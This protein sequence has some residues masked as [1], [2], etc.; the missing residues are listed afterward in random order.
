M[1]KNNLVAIFRR[2][3]RNWMVT[4]INGFGLCV[5]IAASVIIAL[6]VHYEYSFDRY[7]K[8][9]DRIVRVVEN[10]R[11]ADNLLLQA[12]TAPPMGPAFV[13][14]F[15]EVAAFVRFYENPYTV[16]KGGK[17]FYERKAYLVDA[18]VFTVF[19]FQLLKGNSESALAAPHSLVLT[20]HTA[21]KYFGND[22]P[23]GQLL[24]LDRVP[25]TVTGVMSD[26]PENSHFTF[27]FLVSFSTYSTD[28]KQEE[29]VGWFSNTVYTYLLLNTPEDVVKLRNRMPVFIEKYIGD[30]SRR[31]RMFYEDLPLQP[32]TSI[33]LDTPRALE[34]GT[35][36]SR[37][38]LFILCSI[39]LLIIGLACINYIN[40]TTAKA[41]RL[42]KEVG[43]RKILG[44]TR[45][46]L[47]VQFLGESM[48]LCLGATTIGLLIVLLAL[49]SFNS[50]METNL[51][52]EGFDQTIFWPGIGLFSLLLGGISGIYPALITSDISPL[53]TLKN[54][55]V[56]RGN[57][58]LRKA[59]V[60]GQ[61]AISIAIITG[62]LIVLDQLE[63]M[64]NFKVGYDKQ[65]TLIIDF[66]WDQKI[67][68]HLEA[69][70]E[71]LGRTPNV[72]SIT[73]SF[74]VPG[75]RFPNW[76][77]GIET[78]HGKMMGFS[79]NV[80][81]VD[82]D[83]ITAYGIKLVAGRNFSKSPGDD[84]TAFIINEAAVKKFGWSN[85]D[86]IG[87]KIVQRDKTGSVI[88][89]VEDFHYQSLHYKVEPLLLQI[90]L[91]WC[92]N[93]SIKL[94]P[95]DM[96]ITIRALERKW[97]T[98][99]DVP[100][101][102]SLLGEDNEHLYKSERSLSLVAIIFSGLAI[103]IAILGLLGLTTFSVERRVREIGIR[104]VLGSSRLGIVML[105]TG[106]FIGPV[107]LAFVISIPLAIWFLNG[108]LQTFAHH[109][110]LQPLTFM[111]AGAL[112]IISAMF[113]VIFLSLK[114]AAVNPSDSL[115]TE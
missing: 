108:W 60:T 111:I 91:Y 104:K 38:N 18:S 103:F 84:S 16:R 24:E 36:G 53:L 56:G 6:Y 107:I 99:T 62:A 7:H 77:A 115:R 61:F 71:E 64:R 49:P 74:G 20:Q 97:K 11:V 23:L 45:K 9:A 17:T 33:Y 114:A 83:F 67:A 98:L 13:R 94:A 15:S 51:N 28:N 34:H 93:F 57:V 113:V 12:N 82:H 37:S 75:G 87:K 102:Y 85:E 55:S 78:Q 21:H 3:Q 70:K 58:S 100:F 30:I 72:K 89:V 42:F 31:Y 41:T 50:L 68:D 81:P 66:N 110:M 47:V 59:L 19:S 79:I 86:A 44:A 40:L 88:G 90:N 5:G 52:I 2:F 39:A 1:L 80:N 27:D 32:L 69:V 65:A 10:L 22:E 96:A 106:E 8:N 54:G 4:F 48:A 76:D 73:A 63:F 26:V 112:V 43:V 109:I 46:S 92:R 14:E 25:Y 101:E 95:E 35:R 29:E 105:I